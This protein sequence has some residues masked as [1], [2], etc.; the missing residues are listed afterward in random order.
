MESE[1]LTDFFAQFGAQEEEE[2][3]SLS[4][5]SDLDNEIIDVSYKNEKRFNAASKYFHQNHDIGDFVSRKLSRINSGVTRIHTQSVPK[6]ENVKEPWLREIIDRLKTDFNPDDF[7]FYCKYIDDCDK[8]YPAISGRLIDS[9]CCRNHEN[10][11]WFIRSK[12][13]DEH[14]RNIYKFESDHDGRYNTNILFHTDSYQ[15]DVSEKGMNMFN[16]K[17]AFLFNLHKYGK[18][19]FDVFSRGPSVEIYGY[20]VNP[21][22]FRF[23]AWMYQNGVMDFIASRQ[24]AFVKVQLDKKRRAKISSGTKRFRP[25][26]IRL[27]PIQGITS[28]TTIG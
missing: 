4:D 11:L 13:T 21:R 24:N 18:T 26:W 28:Y 19:A 3:Q 5:A 14:G 20:V 27:P 23:Y 2:D 8:N 7:R 17:R 22:R 25:L 15:F 1:I 9:I 12:L 16:Y 6:E 10:S